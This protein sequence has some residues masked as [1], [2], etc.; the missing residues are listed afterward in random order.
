MKLLKITSIALFFCTL[1]FSCDALDELTE[2]DASFTLDESI[3]IMVDEG[4]EAVQSFTQ[5]TSLNL[6]ENSDVADNLTALESVE[7][8]SFTYTYTNVVGNEDAIIL[9]SQLVLGDTM[10]L[11]DPVNPSAV[12]GQLFVIQD[13]AS[14][15]TIATQLRNNPQTTVTYQGELQG[16]PVSFT[17]AIEAAFTVAIDPI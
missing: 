9:S 3:S 8:T 15:N 4:E 7:I 14:L 1:F 17:V 13:T 12:Q 6:A 2:F 16:A 11:I 10:I 5:S